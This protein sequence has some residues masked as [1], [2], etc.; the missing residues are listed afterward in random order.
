M[1]RVGY[2]HRWNRWPTLPQRI[3]VAH[4]TL[5]RP[6]KTCQGKFIWNMSLQ[7]TLNLNTFLIGFFFSLF[8]PDHC[9]GWS[10][11]I[12]QSGLLSQVECLRLSFVW[13][14]LLFLIVSDLFKMA[15]LY[16]NLCYGA[17][18]RITSSQ[19]YIILSCEQPS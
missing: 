2:Y 1:E 16:L 11:Y 5:Y 3:K 15:G 8:K 7:T 12:V 14:I 19:G 6:C 4:R 17:K 13:K 10:G 18:Q 9:S